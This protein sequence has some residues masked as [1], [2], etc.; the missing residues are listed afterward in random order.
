MIGNYERR[1]TFVRQPAPHAHAIGQM[2]VNPHRQARC[3][4]ER[5]APPRDHDRRLTA[6]TDEDP[7]AKLPAAARN[8]QRYPATDMPYAE[9]SHQPNIGAITCGRFC[10]I[11]Q[12]P[13]SRA[14]SRIFGTVSIAS[15]HPVES[16]PP[17]PMPKSTAKP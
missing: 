15:A 10:A 8:S 6:S 12:T 11:P 14:T 2:H 9:R 1:V 17:K 16:T 4:L 13:K 3:K 7:I 5:A